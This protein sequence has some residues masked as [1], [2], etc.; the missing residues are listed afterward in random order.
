[1]R[2]SFDVS[3]GPQKAH[4]NGA[5]LLADLAESFGSHHQRERAVPNPLDFKPLVPRCFRC[6]TKHVWGSCDKGAAS[7]EALSI[8]VLGANLLEPRC[9]L[10][11]QK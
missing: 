5:G 10:G 11:I 1:V 9:E 4:P 7:L 2:I 6:C 3:S 8:T